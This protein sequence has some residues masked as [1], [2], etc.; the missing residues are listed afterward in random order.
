MPALGGYTVEVSIRDTDGEEIGSI[1]VEGGRRGRE[2]EIKTHG[3][4][5]AQP[6]AWV[7]EFFAE[8]ASDIT[9]T[10]RPGELDA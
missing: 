7:A 4:V 6:L 10:G 3:F 1:E 9:E 8:I 5:A 2:A